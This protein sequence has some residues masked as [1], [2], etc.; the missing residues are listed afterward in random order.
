MSVADYAI[1][2]KDLSKVCGR[3]VRAVDRLNLS[4]RRGEVYRFLGPSGAGKTTT[5]GCSSVGPL[6][7]PGR[8]GPSAGRSREPAP[9][10]RDCGRTPFY[11]YRSGLEN[12]RVMGR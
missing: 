4:V 12:L 1:A 3:H 7:L 6:R 5:F 8:A 2:T 10:V 11:P 9:C